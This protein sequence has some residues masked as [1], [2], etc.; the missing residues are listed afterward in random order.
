M[1]QP[2]VDKIVREKGISKSEAESKW[3]TA[4]RLAREQGR[5]GDYAYIMGIFKKMV[6]EK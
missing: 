1:P 4:E 5:S 3:A 2:Y 6:G